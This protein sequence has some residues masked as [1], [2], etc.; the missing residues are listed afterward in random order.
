MRVT[1]SN[2]PTAF[3]PIKPKFYGMKE[4]VEGWLGVM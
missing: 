1:L 2:G 4:W 3:L